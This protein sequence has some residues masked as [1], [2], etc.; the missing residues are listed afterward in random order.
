MTPSLQL[1]R[2]KLEA[3]HQRKI[4]SLYLGSGLVDKQREHKARGDEIEQEI[5][6]LLNVA[7]KQEEALRRAELIINHRALS[8]E[9][10]A[11]DCRLEDIQKEMASI[12]KDVKALELE[13]LK[14]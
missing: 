11:L 5:D 4:A 14:D 3:A 8:E 13:M 1:Q 10:W 12:E 7:D 9:Q 6:L 2:L